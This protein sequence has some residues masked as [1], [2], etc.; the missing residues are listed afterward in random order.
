[1]HVSDKC[2]EGWVPT[3]ALNFQD[4]FTLALMNQV[5]T[6]PQIGTK[7][8]THQY[9]STWRSMRRMWT[10]ACLGAFLAWPPWVILRTSK[11]MCGH[12]LT[13]KCMSIR[14]RPSSRH[15]RRCRLSIK[16]QDAAGGHSCPRFL[17]WW[18]GVNWRI[19][20]SNTCSS[21]SAFSLYFVVA[22]RNN[23]ISP[24]TN[25]MK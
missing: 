19:M 21:E 23:V 6:G 1:M 15:L 9:C 12:N 24:P 22:L 11:A 4:T 10:T 8:A 16:T 5:S 3:K 2:S 14:W 7:F 18:W 25:I 13:N 20:S 17:P